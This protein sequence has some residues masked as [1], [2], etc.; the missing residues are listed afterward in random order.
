MHWFVARSA[1][2]LILL[3]WVV[4]ATGKP[5]TPKHVI[6]L[7]FE[8]RAFDHMLGHLAV[9]CSA[10]FVVVFV[11]VSLLFVCLLLVF[12]MSFVLLSCLC[13]SVYLWLSLFLS[14]SVCLYMCLAG[15]FC[16]SLH[17][18]VCVSPSGRPW[19]MLF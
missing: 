19:W 15:A 2:A 11:V 3:V 8:N 14:V 12:S 6:T 16:L 7:M 4:A 1:A 9:G 5:Y 10:L 18:P 13:L 17:L